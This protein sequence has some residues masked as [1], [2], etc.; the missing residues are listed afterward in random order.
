MT[1]SVQN[2]PPPWQISQSVHETDITGYLFPW[3]HAQPVFVAVGGT[4]DLFLPVFASASKL[5]ELMTAAKTEFD[6]I[7]QINNQSEFLASIPTEMP[8]GDRIRIMVDPHLT[9]TGNT[10]FREVIR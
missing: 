9:G 5:Q 7:K 4:D 3:R 6:S 10:R 8:S 1:E 2:S